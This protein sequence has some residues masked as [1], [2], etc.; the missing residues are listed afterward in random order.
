MSIGG[1]QPLGSTS[2]NYAASSICRGQ[3]SVVLVVKRDGGEESRYSAGSGVLGRHQQLME[4]DKQSDG[5][6]ARMKE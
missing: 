2:G 5:E 1:G 4:A 3:C 6:K